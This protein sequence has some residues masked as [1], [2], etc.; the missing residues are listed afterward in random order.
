METLFK[1]QDEFGN[2]LEEFTM[3]INYDLA[4]INKDGSEQSVLTGTAQTGR[5]EYDPASLPAAGSD[6][7]CMRLRTNIT[8]DFYKNPDRDIFINDPEL[9]EQYVAVSKKELTP[10][11]KKERVRGKQEKMK[12]AFL[13][14]IA[15]VRP[16]YDFDKANPDLEV[17][18]ETDLNP[19]TEV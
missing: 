3:G 5:G 12:N 15:G 14:K 13:Q 4:Y 8:C 9:K 6:F 18:P 17:Q 19:E 11:Q 7:Y 1:V 10:E 16:D 2:S